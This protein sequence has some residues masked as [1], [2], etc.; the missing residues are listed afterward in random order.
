MRNSVFKPCLLRSY[1]KKVFFL[2]KLAKLPRSNPRVSPECVC[3][4]R[5][6][7]IF[8]HVGSYMLAITITYSLIILINLFKPNCC[9]AYCSLL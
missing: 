5:G 6:L 8:V 2:P 1:D 9:S 4:G 3:G 7:Y